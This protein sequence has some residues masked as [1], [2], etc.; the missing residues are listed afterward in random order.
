MSIHLNREL[1]K[2]KRRILFLGS[3]VEEN[4]NA[5]LEALKEKNSR[6]AEL[7][8]DKDFE[9]DELE[10]EIEEECLKI[11]ALHQPVAVDLRFIVS[12][13]KI[14]NDLER[15]G[16]LAVKIAKRAKRIVSFQAIADIYP[17][18]EMA[19]EVIKML[20]NS[21]DALINHDS[22][23]AASVLAADNKVDSF[24]KDIV[25]R[26]KQQYADKSFDIETFVGVIDVSR[27]FERIADHTTNIAEDIIYMVEGKIVRHGR[28]DT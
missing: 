10:I 5:S 12:V 22:G 14:N 23:L 1:D 27:G 21:L 11:L 20:R 24:N 17:I 3:K 18:D 16:D 2:L 13:L 19:A 7:I 8:E 15:I 4:L 6:M 28:A 25:Q 9:I 26:S